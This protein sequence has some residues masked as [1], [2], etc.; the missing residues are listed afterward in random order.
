MKVVK[1][2]MDWPNGNVLFQTY[3][4]FM[5]IYGSL[6]IRWRSC[7]PMC[8]WLRDITLSSNVFDV[9][10]FSVMP[11]ITWEFLRTH[12]FINPFR[13]HDLPVWMIP[14][15]HVALQVQQFNKWQQHKM[16]QECI[17]VGCVTAERLPYPGSGGTCLVLG[18]CLLWG[19]CT[20]LVPGGGVCSGGG[21]PAWSQVG[22]GCLLGGGVP[23]WSQ[24][25]VPAWSWGVSALR[26]GV[27][28]WSPGGCLLLGGTHLVLGGVCLVRYFPPPVNRILDTRLWKYYLGQ[29]FVSAG[30]KGKIPC[31]TIQ[32]PKLATIIC[33]QTMRLH[34]IQKLAASKSVFVIPQTHVHTMAV[35]LTAPQ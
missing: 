5:T 21:V 8:H 1:W 13:F 31:S 7:T 18:G 19:G 23:A 32:Q 27:P 14:K 16:K 6:N 12:S 34:D 2:S 22:G 33:P 35:S 10:R 28:A 3:L 4:L 11:V 20:C 15:R 17:P 9:Y 30:N 24:G 25:G 26:G 29:N